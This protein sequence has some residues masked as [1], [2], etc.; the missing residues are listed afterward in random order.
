[1]LAMEKTYRIAAHRI[2]LGATIFPTAWVFGWASGNSVHFF[3]APG[4]IVSQPSLVLT[5]WL[6]IA[7]LL[8]I[9]LSYGFRRVDI[10]SHFICAHGSWCQSFTLPWADVTGAQYRPNA[11]QLWIIYGRDG[12]NIYVPLWRLSRRDERELSSAILREATQ[13]NIPVMLG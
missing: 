3:Q 9:F 13:R 8:A 12:G 1:M 7:L 10:S 6:P 5:M 2:A 11:T 4:Y